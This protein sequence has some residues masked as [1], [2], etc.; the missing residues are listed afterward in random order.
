M[1]FPLW[2]IHRRAS[3]AS[4]SQKGSMTTGAGEEERTRDRVALLWAATSNSL[5]NALLELGSGRAA[6]VVWKKR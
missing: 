5:G 6:Q 3:A 2:L 1:F 4:H